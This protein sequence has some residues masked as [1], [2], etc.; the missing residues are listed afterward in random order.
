MNLISEHCARF[1]YMFVLLLVVFLIAGG[2]PPAKS[3][4]V[5][6]SDAIAADTIVTRRPASAGGALA[7]SP[8]AH[9][10]RLGL[11]TQEYPE[12][13]P[14]WSYNPYTTGWAPCPQR[15]PGD[16]PCADTMAPSHYRATSKGVRF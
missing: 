7:S 14:A 16:P 6:P 8:T 9:A 10:P 15:E 4:P 5:E 12:T 3:E 13:P 1:L 2:V 11:I